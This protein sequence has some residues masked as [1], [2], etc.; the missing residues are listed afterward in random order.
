V[1]AVTNIFVSALVA[2]VVTLSVEWFAKPWLEVRKDRIIDQRRNLR[3]L[4][5][6]ADSAAASLAALGELEHHN[7]HADR[8]NWI[9][10]DFRQELATLKYG[11]TDK[12]REDAE[13]LARAS[14][15]FSKGGTEDDWKDTYD[16]V[17]AFFAAFRYGRNEGNA[18][19]KL[20]ERGLVKD[21]E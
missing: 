8:G 1:A 12:N 10:H 7:S 3:R 4:R 9:F 14:V 15:S 18:Y 20:I 5:E 13:K 16:Q 21:D 2:L 11:L 6:L 19:N 17:L